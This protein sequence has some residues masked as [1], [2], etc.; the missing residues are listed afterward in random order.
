[1]SRAK[2]FKGYTRKLLRV[3]LTERKTAIEEIPNGQLLKYIGGAGLAARILYDELEPG[4]DPLSYRNKILF[5][6]GPLAGTIA[7]TGSRIGA[8]TKSPM[9][10][11]FFHS[12]AGGCFAAE[13][14]YAGFDGVIV[15]GK[16]EK[17]VYLYIHNGT[18]EIRNATHIWGE[19]T[20]RAHTLLKH[21]I[22]DEAAQ[23]AVIGPAGEKLVRF[24]SVIAG[25]RAMG[26]GGLGAVLGSKKLKG[27]AVRGTGRVDVDDMEKTLKK[28]WELLEVMRGNPSTGQI[29][30]NFGTPVLVD[31]NNSLG[32][33][34]ARNWQTE[35]FEG[36]D[37]LRAETMREKIVVRDKA[38]FACPIRCS[39]YSTVADGPYKGYTVEGPE[40]ENIFSL[41]SMC[42]CSSIETVAAA[43]REC[44]DLGMDAIEAGVSIAFVMEAC[45]KGILSKEDTDGLNVS[46][47]N[48]DIIMPM[49]RKI[50]MREGFGDILAEGVKR[51]SLKIGKGTEAF[52]MQNKGMTFA[53]HSARGMPGF[54]LGY[55]TGPRG[56]S[57]HDS[58]PTGERSGIVQRD[59]VDGKPRYTVDVNHLMILTDSMILCHLAE[60]VWGPIKI[61][62]HVVD[63]LNAVTGM[64]MSVEEAEET[65]ERIWNV[66][67]A[68]A[69]REGSRRK[70]DTLPKRFL[71]EPI[72]DGPSKG[73]VV[74]EDV[75]ETMK[76]EYYRIRGWDLKTGIPMFERLLKL[77]L[78]DIAHDMQVILSS[79]KEV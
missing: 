26:R 61:N 41:G 75:L 4:I 20:Y 6:A 53:G 39:K 13:L 30:P 58:R 52:A 38:C 1:M 7:P 57:H 18:A 23:I 14:K 54:A 45:E 16:S 19:Y 71:S 48:K 43:E 65:A 22:G 10:G 69:V 35:T 37:G 2:L 5:L 68:F 32:V 33:F 79:E 25:G 77:D 8:Y 76:D 55:A 67:R 56:A 49:V 50:G 17:P 42:G 28:T 64:E 44:D 46:F 12:S 60:A 73:M 24:A 3:N 74:G 62:E 21:D 31:A 11:G 63:I 72:P 78:P 70:D 29:L 47:G 40:Y 34:G 36:A 59:T 51:A 66:I 15:E 27:I 9:T